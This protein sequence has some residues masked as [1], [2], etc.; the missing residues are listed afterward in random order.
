M[1]PC[2]SENGPAARRR[3]SICTDVRLDSPLSGTT[4]NGKNDGSASMP[5]D[6][7]VRIFLAV[8][9]R[10]TDGKP[11]P[12]EASGGQPS[13]LPPTA[14]RVCHTATRVQIDVARG[15]G[16]D[17]LTVFCISNFN[18]SEESLVVLI[19]PDSLL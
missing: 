13:R 18:Q 19:E 9:T 14:N 4:T 6:R 11:A 3:Q 17:L 5:N 12:R 10:E 1:W 16:R 2:S 7:W 15:K 8:D